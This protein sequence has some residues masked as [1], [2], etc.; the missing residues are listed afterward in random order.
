[1]GLTGTSAQSFWLMVAVVPKTLPSLLRAYEISSRAAAV[2]FDWAKAGDVLDKIDEEVAEVRHEVES[3]ATGHMSR[4][5]E[6][7]GDLLFAIANLS[8]KLGVEPEVA[9]K[10][11]NRKFRRRFQY[12]EDQLRTLVA[13]FGE[14]KVTAELSFRLLSGLRRSNSSC[15]SAPTKCHQSHPRGTLRRDRESDRSRASCIR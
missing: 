6:E 14:N 4:A 3:G 9:L 12:I 2:G 10:G 15:T 11:S 1:M 13:K 7:M 5:E 8:R